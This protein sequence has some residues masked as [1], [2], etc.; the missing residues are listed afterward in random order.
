MCSSWS[1]G[2]VG[3]DRAH[4]CRCR[5][6][7]AISTSAPATGSAATTA[8]VETSIQVADNSAAHPVVALQDEDHFAQW[9]Q[10]SLF[11]QD[12][13]FAQSVRTPF[14][15]RAT[16]DLWRRSPQTH[17]FR[18]FVRSFPCLTRRGQSS[19]CAFGADSWVLGLIRVASDRE[20]L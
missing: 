3:S 13:C 20:S 7:S 11:G 5:Y 18:C 16:S 1:G 8:A 9:L 14:A 10:M 4:W 2:G 12:A 17:H 15:T 6:R 19:P